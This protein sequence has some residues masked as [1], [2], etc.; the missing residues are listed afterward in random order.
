MLSPFNELVDA[1]PDNILLDADFLTQEQIQAVSRKVPFTSGLEIEQDENKIQRVLINK[2]F[3][4]CRDKTSPP[5]RVHNPQSPYNWCRDG[6]G[7]LETGLPPQN[8][9]S[10]QVKKFI[11]FAKA[12]SATWRWQSEFQ[13]GTNWV[14]NGSHIHFGLKEELFENQTEIANGW[15]VL[16]NTILEVGLCVLP[17]F[18]FGSEGRGSGLFNFRRSALGWADLDTPRL[19]QHSVE[20]NYLV[21]DYDGKEYNFV[22]FNKWDWKTL[23]IE[24]RINETHPAISYYI[25]NMM[26]MIVRAALRAGESPKLANRNA[27]LDEIKDSIQTDESLWTELQNTDPIE[28]VRPIPFL[29]RT[30]KNYLAMFDD[31]QTKY[32]Q[33]TPQMVRVGNLF[34]QR[35]EP[36][37]NRDALWNTFAPRGEFQWQQNIKIPF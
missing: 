37:K 27:F 15:T 19:S 17:W 23:T 35:G 5:I 29:K 20:N 16:Y 4:D 36:W 12:N 9:A 3:A 7:P 34:R 32:W 24:A 11:K 10:T 18:C 31:L 1:R 30:Y 13:A 26:S 6:S 21:P 22:T 33:S 14:G 2:L 28:F 8:L 25:L